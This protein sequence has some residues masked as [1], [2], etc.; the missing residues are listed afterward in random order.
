M[1]LDF[2]AS[3]TTG[4][5]YASGNQVWVYNG[6]A[7][8]SSYQNSGYVRQS[9]TAS[10]GQTSFTVANG[11]LANLVDVYQNGVKLVNGTDVTVTS[12]STVNL[13]VGATT[14]DIIEVIGLSAFSV[15]N[16]SSLFGFRN[17][18]INPTFAINQRAYVSGTATSAANQYILDRWRVV[19]SGQSATF[20]TSGIDTTVTAPAGGIEQV[21]EGNNIEGGNYVLNWTGTAT[22]TVNGTAVTKGV[23]FTLTAGSNATVRFSSGTVTLP[24]LEAGTTASAFERRAFG[25]ELILC[26]R[27]YQTHWVFQSSNGAWLSYYGGTAVYSPV[28]SLGVAMR[29]TPTISFN[30]TSIEYYSYAGVWTAS[31]L[32]AG[33]NTA[34]SFYITATA[35]GD[36]R[37][38]LLRT[39]SG[40]TGPVPIAYFNAEL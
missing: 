36:G 22:A 7:W 1:A 21:I 10:S 30:T 33:S 3:P 19:T 35:D 28:T 11:Y 29:S 34:D 25:F 39:G 4:Q 16:I 24:Q 31:T 20:T 26:Q 12:G 17:R 14:G 38:K 8:A 27:Y 13:A 32:S 5:T 37:G 6:A 9:F 23:S 2:P 18:L 15:A 40:G